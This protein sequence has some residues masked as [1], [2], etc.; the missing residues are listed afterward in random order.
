[1]STQDAPISVLTSL[2]LWNEAHARYVETSCIPQILAGSM[3]APAAFWLNAAANI[4]TEGE[5]RSRVITHSAFLSGNSGLERISFTE[6]YTP[7]PFLYFNVSEMEVQI[8]K[9]IRANIY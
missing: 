7:F 6:G 5:S 1:M 4:S 3:Q 2:E 9:S 8:E